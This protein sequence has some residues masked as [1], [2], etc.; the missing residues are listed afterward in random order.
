MYER[1]VFKMAIEEV[2]LVLNYINSATI[3]LIVDIALGRTIGLST[4][5]Y[6]K[7]PLPSLVLGIAL[8]SISN[9]LRLFLQA[10]LLG[11]APP[12]VFLI[13]L[14]LYYFVAT[15]GWEKKKRR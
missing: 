3:I 5:D 7:K 8:I 12:T 13:L 1:S 15:A 14:V 4:R 6:K 10:Q 2:N 9:F 11:I